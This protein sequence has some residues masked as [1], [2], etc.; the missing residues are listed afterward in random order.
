[1]AAFLGF[2]TRLSVPTDSSTL[3]TG[4]PWRR[5]LDS[6]PASPFRQIARRYLPERLGGVPWILSK[7]KQL[8]TLQTVA[9]IDHIS[10]GAAA[11][12]FRSTEKRIMVKP[13]GLLV[14]VSLTPR[15]ASTPG[16]ST[17]SSTRS[18]QRSCDLGDLI[19]WRVSRLDAFSISPFRT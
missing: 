1:M 19:L 10:Q 4:T 13:H 9:Q 2:G 15:G 12:I 11:D 5:S 3:S 16:L 7:N 17:W 8:N 14:P 6:E 18:L